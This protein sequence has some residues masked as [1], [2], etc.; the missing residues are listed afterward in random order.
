ME[1]KIARSELNAKSKVIS[2]DTIEAEVKKSG[3]KIYYF[4][5][6]NSHKDLISLIEHFESKGMSA[7]LR[8]VKYG[9]DD[10][11]YMYEVHI[12]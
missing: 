2:L 9:L 3:Q 12:I 4:D 8:T 7:Y 5:R 6:E 11:E 10:S 1:L